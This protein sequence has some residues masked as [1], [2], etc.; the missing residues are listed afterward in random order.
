MPQRHRNGAQ[1]HK[2]EVLWPVLTCVVNP[3][4]LLGTL[5]PFLSLF[6]F[7]MILSGSVHF[8][9]F[10]PHFVIDTKCTL[11]A[12]ENQQKKWQTNLSI[13]QSTTGGVF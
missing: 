4:L 12:N 3:Q 7:R 8:L 11:M 10:S 5:N 2:R 9:C 1:R 13:F 6:K